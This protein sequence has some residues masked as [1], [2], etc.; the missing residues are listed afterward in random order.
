MP[1]STIII[2]VPVV[3]GEPAVPG[4]FVTTR[5]I[6]ITYTKEFPKGLLHFNCLHYP[7]PVLLA[8]M[9]YVTIHHMSGEV[10]VYSCELISADI[11]WTKTEIP[12]LNV[13]IK[14]L[15]GGKL[16]T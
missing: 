1:K 15:N 10:K 6:H 9:E 12:T 8:D 2:G 13:K 7:D 4:D 14:L 3:S 5:G 16:V 11:S